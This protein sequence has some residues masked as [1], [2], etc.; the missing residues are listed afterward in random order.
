MLYTDLY[1]AHASADGEKLCITV[2][3]EE[4]KHRIM[5]NE[6]MNVIKDV[7]GSIFENCPV[8]NVVYSRSITSEPVGK[9]DVFS[10]LGDFEKKFPQNI[11]FNA[12]KFQS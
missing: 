11:K 3:D 1:A 12:D 7:I 6:N 8:I 4:K 2:D 5:Q 9:N 10:N